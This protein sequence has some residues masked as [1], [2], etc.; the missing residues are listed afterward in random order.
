MV[1]DDLDIERVSV[2]PFKTDAPLLLNADTVLTLA[3]L[4]AR[5]LLDP[6]VERPHELTLE[7]RPGV[8]VP[9]G[10]DHNIR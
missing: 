2:P 6:T 8:L 5:P 1:I 10:L 9:E 4:L 7:N 3:K